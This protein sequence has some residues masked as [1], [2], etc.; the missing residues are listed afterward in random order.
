M[1]TSNKMEEKDVCHFCAQ[2]PCKWLQYEDRIL[3]ECAVLKVD[4]HPPNKIRKHAY[5]LFMLLKHGTL[6]CGNHVPP[7]D[8]VQDK[9]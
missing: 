1:L 4:G 7:P 9:I 5:H 3:E 6:G 2:C 8:C